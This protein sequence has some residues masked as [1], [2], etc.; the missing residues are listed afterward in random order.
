MMKVLQINSFFSKGGP[1]RIV[2]GIYETIAKNGDECLVAAAR[3]TP[4]PG[5]N[6]Y[7]IGTKLTTYLC[8]IQSRVLD[9]DGFVARRATK[10]L[11]NQIKEYNPDVI[12]LHNLHGYYINVELLFEY[13]KKAGKPVVWTMHDCWAI[14]GHCPTFSEIRCEK[15][16]TGCNHCP[17]KKE[18]PSSLILD[19]SRKNWL[20][21]KESFNGVP[22]LTIVCVSKWLETVIKD[23]YLSDYTTEVIY[24]GVDLSSF[25]RNISN[26]REKY[27]LENKRLILGV[28]LHWV[29]RKGILD[30]ITLAELL[31]ERYQVV[32]VGNINSKD[33]SNRILNISPTSNDDELADIYSACDICLNLSYVESF[34]LTTIESLACGTPVITYDQTAVPEIARQF[35][36][37]VV[38][39]GDIYRLKDAIESFFEQGKKN[40]KSFDVSH[41]ERGLQYDKYY[42]LYKKLC[43]EK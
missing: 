15:Y 34:G 12:H 21:K 43:Y 11:I 10:K 24:N 26:F 14:T 4:L 39:A 18:Y 17:L 25:K 22:N 19:A 1:P 33:C 5:M 6:T 32:L 2:H 8:A 9:N 41:F 7:R 16:L 38:P 29:K 42:N 27:H 30:F 13:L 20:R 31:D 40:I 23:S 36:M 3:E 28:A 35:D 37:P